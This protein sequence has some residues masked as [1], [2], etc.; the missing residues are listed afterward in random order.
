LE[1][2]NPAPTL[3]WDL[4]NKQGQPVASGIYLYRL[5]SGGNKKSGKIALIR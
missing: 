4:K 3:L 5:E 1:K 2:D